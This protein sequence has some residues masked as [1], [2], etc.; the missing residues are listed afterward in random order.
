MPKTKKTFLEGART[1]PRKAPPPD[2]VFISAPQVCARYGGRSFMWLVR[3][4]AIDQD[5]PR[6]Q[7]FGRL[8]FFK[9]HEL[10]EYE[11]T[12]AARAEGVR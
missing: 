1:I 5:F 11:R 7:Y 9:I 12:V 3:K 6:P 8:R 10:E 4:L 2:A